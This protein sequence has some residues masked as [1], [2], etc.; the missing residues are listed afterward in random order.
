M[1]YPYNTPIIL[2]DD[3]FSS[4]GGLTGTS[5]QLMREAAY[6]VAEQEMS[7]YIGT[8]L[9]PTT[10]TGQAQYFGGRGYI[11]TDWGYVSNLSGV[12]ALD[13][14]GN[15]LFAITGSPS[16]YA[17]IR[18]DTYGYL[19]VNDMLRDRGCYYANPLTFEYSYTAGL[20]TGTANLPSMLMALSRAAQLV[21]NELYEV[22]ANESTGDVGV[23]KFTI[24]KEYSEE[25]KP[26]KNTIFGS[27]P[28]AAWVARMADNAVKKARRAFMI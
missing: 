4:Y 13:Y 3:I 8:F 7:N 2:T 5:T 15:E 22:K 17:M 16:A 25:R 6:A 23:T 19:L 12:R 10:V 27:S 24:L 26:W 11:A 9:L 21:L 18:E 20:P 14:A 1:I 28:A